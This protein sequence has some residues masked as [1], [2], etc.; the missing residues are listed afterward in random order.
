MEISR[1]EAMSPRNIDWRRLTAQEIL[2]YDTEGI[3]VPDVYLQWAKDF[4]KDVSSNDKDL[5]TYAADTYGNNSQSDK[6]TTVSAVTSSED[7]AAAEVSQVKTAKEK[8]KQMEDNGETL[9]S[10]GGEFIKDSK[11]M[12]S[13]AKTSLNT[14]SSN[15]EILNAETENIEG[16]IQELL[17]QADDINSKIQ[18]AKTQKN[19]MSKIENLRQQLQTLGN[20]AQGQLSATQGDINAYQMVTEAQREIST[21]AIDFGF[22]TME[23]GKELIPV[24]PP[25]GMILGA[26]AQV[27]GNNAVKSGEELATAITSATEQNQ[28]STG[29]IDSIKSQ[30][31]A[32]TGVAE[33]SGL[34]ENNQGNDKDNNN[35]NLSKN[36]PANEKTAAVTQTD[37]AAS[38]SIDQILQSKI[39]R[40]EA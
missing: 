1:I 34:A 27:R 39:R 8:R 37:K 15:T 13:D 31:F 30:V 24:V 33:N 29:K 36:D 4:I 32:K 6:A 2:K 9:V 20:T 19:S 7:D 12:D 16:S 35:D 17:T 26:I 25:T 10:I 28:T 23:I 18:T 40:G 3:E 22:E 11:E 14:I 5:T 38:A 21:T